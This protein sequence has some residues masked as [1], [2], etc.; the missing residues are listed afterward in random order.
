[1]MFWDISAMIVAAFLFAG[2][3]MPIKIFYK[4]TPKWFI[5]F[6]AGLG[7]MS[8]QVFSEYTW[9][10][11]TKSKLPEG[12]VVVA[13]VPTTTWFRPWSYIKPQ[14]FQFVV[15]DTA[16]V[17]AIDEKTKQ[18]QVYFFERQLPA[19]KLDVLFDCQ[20]DVQ[21]YVVNN[22]LSRLNW[23]KLA[24]TDYALKLICK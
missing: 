22:D 16:N 20:K 7:M 24:Y 13:S 19:Q 6:M 1:M 2:L 8:Y 18:A 23:E 9:F 12:S 5:P 10:D 15:L 14:I 21:T 11:N 4:K 3:A 17:T